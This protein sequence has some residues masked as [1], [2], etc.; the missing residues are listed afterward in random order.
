[1]KD[2]DFLNSEINLYLFSEILVKFTIDAL[3]NK[4]INNNETS[5]NLMLNNLLINA[6]KGICNI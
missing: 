4:P 1:M 5:G 6:F 2:S 3:K